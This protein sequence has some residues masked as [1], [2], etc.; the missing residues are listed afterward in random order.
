[1]NIDHQLLHVSEKLV[2]MLDETADNC[3]PKEIANVVKTHSKLAVGSAWIPVPGADVAAGAAVIW[4]MYV[5]INNK[6][7]IPFGENIMKS[8]G[9]G[10][11][12][13]LASYLAMTGV[14]SAIKII[15]CEM[16][17]RINQRAGFCL[18]TKFGQRGVIN[19]SKTV[20]IVGGVISGSFD[21]IKTKQIADRAYKTFIEENLAYTTNHA[22]GDYYDVEY[23]EV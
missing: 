5:R 14:A 19:L 1:M 6:L 21:G 3:L 22:T 11:A 20:P 10:V 9:S 12:T 15:P 18:V 23:T 2:K 8:I 17:Y 13:N 16:L 4:G 7:G